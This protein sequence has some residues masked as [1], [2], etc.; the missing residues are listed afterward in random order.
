MATGGIGDTLTGLC[1]ALIAQGMTAYD[2]ACLG[3]WI[4]GRAA[5]IALYRGLESPET[6]TATSVLDHLGMAFQDLRSLSF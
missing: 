5:E 3:S 2:A 6:L 4:S 1:S